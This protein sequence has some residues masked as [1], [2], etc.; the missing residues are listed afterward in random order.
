LVFDQAAILAI[1]FVIRRF[2]VTA[3]IAAVHFNRA[4]QNCVSR[5]CCHRF[6]EFVLQN[7]SGAILNVEV[8]AHLQRAMTFR[9]VREHGHGGE[10][11]LIGQ[12]TA[13][14]DR[15]AGGAELGHAAFAFENATARELVNVEASAFR[16]E[17]L[18]VFAGCFLGA[19]LTTVTPRNV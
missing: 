6:A 2:D 12:L 19:Y 13:R 7:E 10:Y 18:G 4:G 17:R 16:A 9:A 3:E 14:K 15:P 5:F 11:V 1:L 8:A